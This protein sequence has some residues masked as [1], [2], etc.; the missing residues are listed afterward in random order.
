MTSK[1]GSDMNK[2]RSIRYA[3]IAILAA[4]FLAGCASQNTAKL[5]PTTTPTRSITPTTATSLTYGNTKYGFT[6]TLPSSWTGYRLISDTWQGRDVATGSV[7][8]TGPLISIRHP[9]W[10]LAAKS[11]DIP[12][13]VFTMAQWSKIISEKLS[14]GAAPIPPSELGRNATYVFALPARY[15]YAFPIGYQEV[16]QIIRSKP[17]HAY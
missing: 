9:S 15:N 11:Q 1:V 16:D 14:V 10:T 13:M 5:S 12:I 4:V 6:F 7:T 17:L 8:Q 3:G 2:N